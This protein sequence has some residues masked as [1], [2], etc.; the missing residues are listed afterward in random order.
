MPNFDGFPR[1]APYLNALLGTLDISH[2]NPLQQN[3][4]HCMDTLFLAEPDIPILLARGQPLHV[5][6]V[7]PF[8]SQEGAMGEQINP[9]PFSCQSAHTQALRAAR[10]E[11]ITESTYRADVALHPEY[12]EIH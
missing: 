9:N 3:Y 12:W 10:L 4:A 8:S 6:Y 11:R 5:H 7:L 1:S 2:S